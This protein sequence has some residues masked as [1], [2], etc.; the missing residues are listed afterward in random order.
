MSADSEHELL[1]ANGEY[2]SAQTQLQKA[3]AIQSSAVLK[4]PTRDLTDQTADVLHFLRVRAPAY[5][6]TLSIVQAGA[7]IGLNVAPASLQSLARK[8]PDGHSLVE[9][10]LSMSG[11]YRDVEGLK[12]FLDEFAEFSTAITHLYLEKTDIRRLSIVIMGIPS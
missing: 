11:T 4:Y 3:Q 9:L 12:A 7:D 2:A 6:V 8:V 1:R 10:P 5:G